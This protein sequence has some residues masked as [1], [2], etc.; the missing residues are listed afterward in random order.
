[1]SDWKLCKAIHSVNRAVNRA[2]LVRPDG[3]I[4]QMEAIPHIGHPRPDWYPTN[5]DMRSFVL[6]NYPYKIDRVSRHGRHTLHN[7]KDD[8]VVEVP[9]NSIVRTDYRNSMEIPIDILK[10]AALGADDNIANVQI[11]TLCI[12][13]ENTHV[14]IAIPLTVIEFRATNTSEPMNIPVVRM[15]VYGALSEHDKP[16]FRLYDK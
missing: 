8:I 4:G 14:S 13:S 16:T 6:K 9:L 10:S 5:K 15:Y 2:L 1:M 7:M 3:A 12:V 11:H